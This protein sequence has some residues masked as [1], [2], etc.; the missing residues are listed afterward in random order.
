MIYLINTTNIIV[1]ISVLLA[2]ISE[3]FPQ[4][5]LSYWLP[6]PHSNIYPN[7]H[8]S[9]SYF[10]AFYAVTR[11]LI[12]ITIWLPLRTRIFVL[13]GNNMI[14]H[15]ATR[16]ALSMS[17]IGR[18]SKENQELLKWLVLGY[19]VAF[20]IISYVLQSLWP[21]LVIVGGLLISYSG[22]SISDDKAKVVN[23]NNGFMN[24]TKINNNNVTTYN[25]ILDYIGR[26]ILCSGFIYMAHRMLM[27]KKSI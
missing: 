2:C 14:I 26:V 27:R 19:I 1:A 8:Q 23:P 21:C 10:S 7:T 16:Y 6:P 3:L 9:D 24:I 15:L 12:S 4:L 13:S 11:F 22:R 17:F 20:C 5:N 18:F 25:P